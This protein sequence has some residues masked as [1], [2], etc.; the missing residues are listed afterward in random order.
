MELVRADVYL[1]I[2]FFISFTSYML[3]SDVDTTHMTAFYHFMLETPLGK[4]PS[5]HR[6]PS[7]DRVK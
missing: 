2:S 5:K 6:K 4:H 3:G 7:S 1:C